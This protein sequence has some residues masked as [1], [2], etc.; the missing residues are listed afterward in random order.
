MSNKTVL[1]ETMRLYGKTIAQSVQDGADSMTATQLVAQ[2]DFIP[3]FSEAIKVKNMLERPIGF[4]VTTAMGNVC[5]LLNVYDSTI[6]TDEP[7]TLASLW[8]FKWSTDPAYAKEFISLST[9]SYMV[10][11]CCIWES[12]TY[13]CLADNT[14]HD[15]ETLPTAWEVVT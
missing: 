9:S 4:A 10:N 1:M 6:F 13:R 3:L 5:R 12:Q 11:D 8:G 14:T 15:P 7:E 2:A